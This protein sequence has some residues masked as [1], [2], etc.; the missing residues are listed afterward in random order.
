MAMSTDARIV[1]VNYGS[2]DLL[3]KNYAQLPDRAHVVVVDNFSG[4]DER[5]RITDLGARR[6]WTVLT[7]E[8]NLGFGDGVN[9]GVERAFADGAAV[10]IVLNPDA[11]MTP[12]SFDGMVE[13][14]LAHPGSLVAPLTSNPDGSL[15]YSGQEVNIE[16][17]T[18][19]RADF[20]TAPHP[21]LTG[22]CLAFTLEAWRTCGGF[23]GEYF[24][25]WEDVDISW[26]MV[27]RGGT[28][29]L[30]DTVTVVHEEGGTQSKSRVSTKSPTYI[31]YNCRNRLVFA[32]RN[33]TPEQQRHWKRLS[34]RYGKQVLLSGG[35]RL[36][37]VSPKHVWAAVKGTCAGLKHLR[38]AQA[39]S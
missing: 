15:N 22:A 19:R 21:W 4:A 16:Q 27:A 2:A 32:A 39:A 1:V 29:H 28:L 10:V 38:K 9:L 3:E 14:S 17:G 36:A 13:S 6:G 20:A 30:E 24:L 5:A 11:I 31:Y 26:A 12:E 7:P 33:L 35:S 8:T 34:Y 23:A 37:V 25:Y 18:T